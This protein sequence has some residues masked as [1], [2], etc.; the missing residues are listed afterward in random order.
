VA[1]SNILSWIEDWYHSQCDGRWEHDFGVKIGTIDN[2]GWSLT[3]DLTGTSKESAEASKEKIERSDTDWVHYFVREKRFE[4]FGG[5]KN[6][7]EMLC[8]F[9]NWMQSGDTI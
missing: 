4:A 2:P 8:I 3:V 5:A 7:E 6:L 1:S 9:K